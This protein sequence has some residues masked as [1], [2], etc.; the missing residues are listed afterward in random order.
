MTLTNSPTI[1]ISNLSKS[2][3]KNLVLNNISLEFEADKTT[4]VLG[5]SGTGKSVMFK[6]ITGLLTPDQGSIKVG[7]L[8]MTD[9]SENTKT[10]IRRSIGMLF[11]SAALFDSLTLLENVEFPL[12]RLGCLSKKEIREKALIYINKVDLE[13]FMELLPGQVSMGIRKR[14]GIARAMITE[15]KI[16]L[17]DEP[18]TGLDPLV[19]QDIYDLINQLRSENKFTGIIVSHEIPEVFQCC[20]K[21]VM[22]YGGLVHFNG[23]VNDFLVNTNPIVKQ[24]TSG[25]TTGPIQISV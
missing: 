1:Q 16:L 17:F 22:L 8:S 14:A 2:F 7:N 15:P 21:V 23:S 4:A 24:F 25:D 3:G 13:D 6:L 10:E 11:Q 19:G 5:P 18:N 12:E 9:S 20:D